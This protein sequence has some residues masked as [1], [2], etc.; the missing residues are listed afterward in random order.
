MNRRQLF[1]SSAK[2]TIASAFKMMRKA[3]RDLWFAME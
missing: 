1:L 2:V 3:E